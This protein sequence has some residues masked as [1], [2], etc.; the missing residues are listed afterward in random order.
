[1]KQAVE[2]EKDSQTESARNDALAKALGAISVIKKIPDS[3]VQ[4][5][6]QSK[7]QSMLMDFKEQG[8]TEEQIKE[9]ATPEN[10]EKY[11][12]ISRPQAEK[13]VSIYD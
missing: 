11:S 2:G 3:L 8:S 9:M 4:E 1:M 7:F 13:T 5:N 6:I 10:Y 12:K